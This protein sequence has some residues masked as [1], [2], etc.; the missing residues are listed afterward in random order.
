MDSTQI[1]LTPLDPPAHYRVFGLTLRSS[2]ALPALSPTAPGAVDLDLVPGPRRPVPE[3]RFSVLDDVLEL[4][5]P[6]TGR[7][8]I[9]PGGRIEYDPTPGVDARLIEFPILGPVL[10]LALQL[11]G[12]LVLHG[13]A[14]EIGGRAA[15]FLGDKGAGKSTLAAACLRAGHRLLTDD[16][17]V[18]EHKAD[19][20]WRVLPAFGQLKLSPEAGALMP[21]GGEIVDL[22]EVHDLIEKRHFRGTDWLSTEGVEP[23][24]IA[25]LSRGDD[26]DRTDYDS[27]TALKQIMRFS[28]LVR[29]DTARVPPAQ[30]ARLFALAAELA[31]RHGAA[32]LTVPGRIDRL[33]GMVRYLENR[34]GRTP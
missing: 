20:S 24:L 14:V 3:H 18:L 32:A 25:T 21:E 27:A 23:G 29:F 9:H 10:G 4:Y 5:F 2:Y 16:L 15:I 6:P 11:R 26:P 17:A 7:F 31:G 1:P 22:S 12:L 30:T 33:P 8:A 13:S 28:Y 34:I 19:G